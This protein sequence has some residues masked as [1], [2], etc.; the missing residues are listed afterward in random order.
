TGPDKAKQ[1]DVLDVLNVLDV[2]RNQG[3]GHS[4]DGQPVPDE[5]PLC[6]QPFDLPNPHCSGRDWH[7]NTAGAA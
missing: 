6:A 4:T 7:A 5:C 2:A 3:N 1:G